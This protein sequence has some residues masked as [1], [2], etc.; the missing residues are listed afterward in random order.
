MSWWKTALYDTCS[1]VTLDKLLQGKPTP[2]RWF[3]KAVLALEVS[4]SEEQMLVDTAE[5]MKQR[6]EQ[7]ALPSPAVLSKL[8]KSTALSNALSDV[9]KLVFATAVHSRLAVVTGNK[10]LGKAIQQQGLKVGDMAI[11]LQE[12]VK[13]RKVQA[14]VV[15]KMVRGLVV[16]NVCL[17]RTPNPT[18][19]HLKNHKFPG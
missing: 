5:R 1:L 3:P 2:S 4:I 14:S 7:C 17:L 12:L 16:R 18:W 15:E 6:I 19:D 13:S 11:I 8:L 9:E 10:T